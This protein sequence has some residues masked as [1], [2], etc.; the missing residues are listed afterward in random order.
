MA[1]GV[2]Q[3]QKMLYLAKIFLEETDEEH[4]L[5]LAEISKKL[6]EYGVTGDRKTLYLDFEELRRFGLDILTTKEGTVTTYRLVSRTFELPELKLLVDSVQSSKFI[7]EKKS[8]ALIRK[9]ESLVSI[10]E[11]GQFQRQVLTAGR[12]KSMNESIYYSVDTLHTAIHQQRQI[13]FQ[14]VQWNVNKEPEFRHDGAFY[15]VGPWHLWWDQAYY[16]LIGYDAQAGGIRHYRVDKMKN[17]EITDR[18]RRGSRAMKDFDPAAYTRSLF[19]MYSGTI[20]RVTLEG[21][22]EMVGV[23]L[24]RFGTEIPIT[25]LNGERFRAVVE[26]AVSP[27]FYGWIASLGGDIVVRGPSTVVKEM[28]AFSQRLARQYGEV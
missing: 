9:L 23:L 6:G 17:I 24:D 14:Y 7:T 2:N 15:D 8:E 20:L 13:R 1:K 5:T 4:G 3:K 21:A 11:A 12:V 19:G 26:V 10:H 27:Q 18:P 28:W 22:N 16:Y 25:P